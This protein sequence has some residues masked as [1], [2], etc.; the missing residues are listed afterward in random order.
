MLDQEN[1]KEELVRYRQ[2]LEAEVL[3]RKMLEREV[4]N[5]IHEER[6]RFGSQLH[7]GLCQELTAA[8]MFAKHLL[9]KMETDKNL[10]LADLKRISDML[11]DAVDEAR[12][13]A[14]GLY[15]GELEGTSLMH[16]LEELLAQTVGVSCFFHCPKPILIQDDT[17]ATHLYRIAQEAISNALTHGRAQNIEIEFTQSAKH[18]TLAIKDDGMGINKDLKNSNGIGL[19]TMRYR[20]DILNGSLQIKSNTPQGT[21]VECSLK[22]H[23]TKET[24][25]AQLLNYIVPF[26]KINS[27]KNHIAF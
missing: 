4:L 11:L 17:T 19:K 27:D 12:N 24:K 3:Q 20:A 7:D 6:R 23:K 1:E 9:R 5:I 2:L 22:S 21:I 15:P 25:I 26:N 10:E 8:L 16:A 14:R 18:I 13:T